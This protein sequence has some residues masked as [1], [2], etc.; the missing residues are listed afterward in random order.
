MFDW[1]RYL[2]LAIPKLLHVLKAQL[3]VIS[4]GVVLKDI[5]RE[6]DICL[7]KTTAQITTMLGHSMSLASMASPVS[8][9]LG[10]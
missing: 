4:L 1:S 10:R 6:Y 2:E 5:V 3:V 9:F 7:L 8:A